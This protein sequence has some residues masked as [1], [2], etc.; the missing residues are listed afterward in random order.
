LRG[1]ASEKATKFTP[2]RTICGDE[3]IRKQAA[4]G[5]H[6]AET[7]SAV[8]YRQDDEVSTPELAIQ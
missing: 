2:Q 3:Y 6:D 5:D 4:A 1:N 8:W 7:G